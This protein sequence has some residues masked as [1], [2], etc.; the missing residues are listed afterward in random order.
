MRIPQLLL[1]L[2]SEKQQNKELLVDQ[3]LQ[4]L[5]RMKTTAGYYFAI[6]N[7]LMKPI[8]TEIPRVENGFVYLLVSLRDSS[9]KAIFIGETT[10]TTIY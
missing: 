6:P 5:H 9:F 1:Q 3:R 8:V 2:F 4:S 10:Q 7:L